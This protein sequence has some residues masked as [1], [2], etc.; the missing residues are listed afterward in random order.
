MA[1]TK[2]GAHRME[3]SYAWSSL[4]NS[5]V[6]YLPFGSDFPTD[7][8]NPFHGIHSAI[9]RQNEYGLPSQGFYPKERVSIHQ[10]IKGYTIGKRNTAIFMYFI[11]NRWL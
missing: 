6:T 3:T 11:I 9:T 10:A 5:G 2:L 1:L 8:M 7:V 4:L